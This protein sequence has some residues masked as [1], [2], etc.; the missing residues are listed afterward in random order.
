MEST[1]E[2]SHSPVETPVQQ[3]QEKI[4]CACTT[5]IRVIATLFAVIGIALQIALVVQIVD[6]DY[7]GWFRPYAPLCSY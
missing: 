2:A 3:R 1:Q 7:Y 5:S 4:Q 6:S